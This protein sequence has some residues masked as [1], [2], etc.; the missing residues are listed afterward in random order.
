MVFGNVIASQTLVQGL[1]QADVFK[2]VSGESSEVDTDGENSD[3][4]EAGHAIPYL[5]WVNSVAKQALDQKQTGYTE[6]CLPND[7]K[8]LSLIYLGSELIL[9]LR[10]SLQALDK[11][12][13]FR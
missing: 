9:C 5:I 8:S 7:A 3:Q 10:I 1:F 4:P 2:T 6:Y 13:S 12:L 11:Y